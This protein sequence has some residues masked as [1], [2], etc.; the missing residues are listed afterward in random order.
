MKFIYVQKDAN[1][2]AP[3]W[4]KSGGRIEGRQ[5]NELL[6]TAMCMGP[7]IST[8]QQERSNKVSIIY[9][10]H[11]EEHTHYSEQKKMVNSSHC[12]YKVLAR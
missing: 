2:G 10:S 3:C 6:T 5:L 12:R 8:S 4:W 7:G 9:D 1:N 11:F